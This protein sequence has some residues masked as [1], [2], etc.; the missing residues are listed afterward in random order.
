M[1][2]TDRGIYRPG[3]TAFFKASLRRVAG[4][5]LAPMAGASVLFHV[6]GPTSEDALSEKVT[7][8][9]LGSASLSF[10][11]PESAKLGRYQVRVEDPAAPDPPIA[12]GMIQVAE[13]EAPR[14]AVDVDVRAGAAKPGSQGAGRGARGDG[15]GALPLRGAD[16]R[17]AGELDAEA[18]RGAFPRGAVDGRAHLSPS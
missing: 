4:D 5:K 7:T 12:K 17:R 3:S 18:I 6:V 13:F 14:F 15:A 9:D 1:V 16:G 2:V 11:V 10:A 8:N